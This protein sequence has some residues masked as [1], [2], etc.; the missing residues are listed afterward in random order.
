M[1]TIEIHGDGNHIEVET[2][3]PVL[4]FVEKL[5]RYGM[6]WMIFSGVLML[7]WN[8]LAHLGAVHIN[9]VDATA[10][11]ANLFITGWTWRGKL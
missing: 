7:M 4:T 11:V 6:L 8:A 3:K 5:I 10:I 1:S 2:Q 9:F